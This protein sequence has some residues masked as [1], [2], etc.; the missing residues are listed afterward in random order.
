M[1]A[2]AHRQGPE[3]RARE[4][5]RAQSRSLRRAGVGGAAASR[6]GGAAARGRRQ[7]ARACAARRSAG[8]STAR[9]C[10]CRST[11]RSGPRPPSSACSCSCIPAAPTTS[12]RR[13]RSRPRRSRQH[14]RQP[15]RDD[16]L[17]VAA[18]LR[19][20]LRQVPRICASAARTPAATCRRISGGPKWRARCANNA[21][22]AN[23][24]K[25]SEYLQVADPRRHDGVLRRGPA[26]SGGARWASSQVVYGT[27]VPFNWPVTVD[28]VLNATF[29]SDAEKE[30]IL[31]GNLHEAAADQFLSI[32][33]T[34]L[35]ITDRPTGPGAS[36]RRIGSRC[37]EIEDV[38][39]NSDS[40][41]CTESRAAPTASTRP[42]P[43]P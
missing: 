20:H 13:A 10:R 42:R 18:D 41:T 5:G 28:L 15:A 37:L 21:N 19:R 22:C 27:D 29:L 33:S 17:P 35:R 40:R 23:K 24:K 9:I 7:A 14:H 32:R 25:P 31:G 12:S 2:R 16:L 6:S 3:R 39:P 36:L 30:A 4:V 8:T 43:E 1:L 34:D 11:T 26:P 38:V